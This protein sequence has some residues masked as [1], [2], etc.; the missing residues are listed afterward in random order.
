[1]LLTT[2]KCDIKYVL[3]ETTVRTN[4][5]AISFASETE[6]HNTINLLHLKIT[7]SGT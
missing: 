4:K 2:H 5:P 1:M 7:M 3:T 6:Q